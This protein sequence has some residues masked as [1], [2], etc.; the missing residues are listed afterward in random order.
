MR[1]EQTSQESGAYSA[2]ERRILKSGQVRGF[3]NALSKWP[4][5]RETYVGGDPSETTL[6]STLA[7]IT[8]RERNPGNLVSSLLHT[9]LYAKASMVQD[10]RKLVTLFSRAFRRQPMAAEGTA[11]AGNVLAKFVELPPGELDKQI[12]ALRSEVVRSN[13]LVE[14]L[15][16]PVRERFSSKN[17][18]EWYGNNDPS[19]R[20][21]QK[22]EDAN[23]LANREVK[24]LETW[25]HSIHGIDVETYGQR[26][27]VLNNFADRIEARLKTAFPWWNPSPGMRPK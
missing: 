13:P 15:P 19:L 27:A 2:S 23:N 11:A 25:F 4:V 8:E 7:F 22:L 3:A 14:N 6:L 10:E 5:S 26:E 9:D 18:R 17:V 1:G 12:S 20:E 21:L 16:G 24:L